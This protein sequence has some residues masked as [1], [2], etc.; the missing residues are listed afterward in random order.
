M[1]GRASPNFAKAVHDCLNFTV[2]IGTR[3]FGGANLFYTW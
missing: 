2:Q 1:S 3:L